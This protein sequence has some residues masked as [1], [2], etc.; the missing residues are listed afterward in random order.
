MTNILGKKLP[1]LFPLTL[2]TPIIKTFFSCG[3]LTWLG[4]DA[5]NLAFW[6]RVGGKKSK[7]FETL[8]ISKPN[9][10]VSTEETS[11]FFF[12]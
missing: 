8:V 6:R 3:C 2:P 4:S 9:I 1:L 5:I 7:L 12:K 10:H 11:Y